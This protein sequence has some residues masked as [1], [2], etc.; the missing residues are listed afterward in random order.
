MWGFIG[1]G[2]RELVFLGTDI[3]TADS[4]QETLERYLLPKYQAERHR[5]AVW[6]Q[7]G[8]PAH[9]AFSTISFLVEHRVTK[10]EW[11]PYSPDLNPIENLW[12]YI[13]GEINTTRCKTQQ[14]LQQEISRVWFSIPMETI[15]RFVASFPERLATCLARNGDDCQM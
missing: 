9:S 5:G 8:A 12:G 13:K 2:V 6:M 7:D 14:E 11:P 3:V 4:Y 15:N 10:L 1:H